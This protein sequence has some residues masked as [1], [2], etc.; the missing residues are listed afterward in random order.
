MFLNYLSLLHIR[1]LQGDYPMH[2]FLG[3]VHPV[4]VVAHVWR[5]DYLAF[6]TIIL[7]HAG[8]IFIVNSKP[9]KLI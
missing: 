8:Y 6:S 1:R 3:V 4:F 7:I 2:T 9:Y 5:A